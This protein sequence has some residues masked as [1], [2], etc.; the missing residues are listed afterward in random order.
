MR[1]FLDANIILDDILTRN[2]FYENSHTV[3][4]ICKNK[5]SSLAPHTVSNIFILL[6]NILVVKNQKE[7]Y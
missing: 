7:F 4:K 6:K 5:K 2:D 3:I 1:I